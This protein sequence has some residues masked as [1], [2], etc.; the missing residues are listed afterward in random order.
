MNQRTSD[1]EFFGDRLIAAV[2]RTAA[3]PVAGMI[4]VRTLHGIAAP[5]SR[6]WGRR[7]RRRANDI[8]AKVPAKIEVKVPAEV[9]IKVPAE[10]AVKI[11]AEVAAEVT[12]AL[13]GSTKTWRKKNCAAQQCNRGCQN[14]AFCHFILP[15]FELW[16]STG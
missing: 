16:M 2:I 5:G 4:T 7:R 6:R 8:A 9:A 1:A 11:P 10:V 13:E 14:Q 12:T 3:I 15:F